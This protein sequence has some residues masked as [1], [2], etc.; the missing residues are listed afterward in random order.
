MRYPKLKVPEKRRVL[1][2]RFRGYDH[3]PEIPA[4]AFRDMQNLS[5]EAAPLLRTR[6]RRTE[7]PALESCPSYRVNA[8]GGRG[9]AVVLDNSGTLWCG[10]RALPRLLDGTVSL[11]ASDGAGGAAAIPEPD[12]VLQAL[13]SPGIYYY[14]YDAAAQLWRPVNGGLPLAGRLLDPGERTDGMILRLDYDYSLDR[15]GQRQLVFLG[16]WVCIFPDGKYANTVKLR[17][18]AHMEPFTDYG[19]I[20][21]YNEC[22]QGGAIFT[23][24]DAAGQAREILWSATAP[25][26][27]CWVDSSEPEPTLRI[28]S[29]SQGLWTELAPYVKCSLPNIARGLRAGDSVELFCRLESSQGPERMLEALWE[30]T[31]VLTAA[32]H[33]PGGEGRAEGAGD[34][35]ILP[36]LLPE[37]CELELSWH[38][39]SY[40]S[41]TRPMPEMDYVVEAGNRL[42]GCRW[43]GGVNELYGSRL[44]D[45][46]SWTAFEGLSTD[47]YRVARGHDGPFTGA[48]VLGGCPLFFRADSLEKIY[49]AADGAHGV[50]TVSLAG[51]EPGSAGSAAVIRDRLYY[52]SAQG[53][54]CYNGTLPVPVSAALGETRFKNA[55]AG[56]LGSRYYVTME[57]P[58]GSDSLFVLDTDTGLW[59]REDELRFCAAYE[60]GD[61]L[62]LLPALGR[63][64]LCVG[65]AADSQGVLWWAETGELAP[66]LALR[67]YVTRLQISARLDPGAS[68]RV[69]LCFDGGPWLRK[70]ELRGNRLQTLTLPI[71]PRRC[72]RLRLRL[73]GS[74]GME[75]HSLSWLTEPGSDV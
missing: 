46:R 49:P 35:L 74:G 67:R 48:A 22:E 42:W 56:T 72:Q 43:G 47:S 45:F 32:W 33:D 26:S 13:N 12:P 21:Q 39:R 23:P 6:R 65:E 16:G 30:G 2:D 58:D 54:C 38:D 59:H 27:G 64:L 15:A 7:V 24:C 8:I 34:Y 57:A 19:S 69:Y 75:L 36:C 28:W 17:S 70:G 66:K 18:A 20:A 62:Y 61:R 10:G 63:G 25:A 73:E 1:I 31:H 41:V 51:I 44:G 9:R 50:V 3:R 5:G 52:K 53:I 71:T 11:S 29:Q 4:G 60:S 40:F 37:A 14:Q 68:M 55:V